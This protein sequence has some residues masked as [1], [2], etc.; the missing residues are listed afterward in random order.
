MVANA[1][2]MMMRA[3]RAPRSGS[4]RALFVA[5]ALDVFFGACHGGGGAGSGSTFT[6]GAD[7]GGKD[8]GGASGKPDC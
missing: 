4:V 6:V 2:A 5:V 1:R 3:A 7:A 8:G